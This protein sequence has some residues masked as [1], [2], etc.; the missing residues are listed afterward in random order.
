[1]LNPGTSS[2]VPDK[3]IL[4]FEVSA[5]DKQYP[6]PCGYQ[7]PSGRVLKIEIKHERRLIRG[8]GGRRQPSTY[9]ISQRLGLILLGLVLISIV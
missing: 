5:G 4:R 8:G 9:Y 6:G 7:Y 3:Y 2:L 1:M